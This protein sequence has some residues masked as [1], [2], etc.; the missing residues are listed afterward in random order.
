MRRAALLSLL[1]L[2][3]ASSPSQAH[4][5]QVTPDGLGD[6]PTIQAAVDSSAAGDSILVAEGTYIE[7]IGFLPGRT[8][9]GSWDPSFTAFDVATSPTI[10]DG[11]SSGSCLIADFGTEQDSL[12]LVAHLKLVNGVGYLDGSETRGGGLFARGLW[13]VR[14]CI[15]E[16]N[17]A[18]VGGGFSSESE[19]LHLVGLKAEENVAHERGA[20]IALVSFPSEWTPR[21]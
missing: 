11:D 12:G 16:A 5:W 17:S 20:G 21:K 2:F 9:I 10:V 19:K 7:N 1:G 6:A 4:T 18:Y 3:L 8:L 14:H 13:N 15:A